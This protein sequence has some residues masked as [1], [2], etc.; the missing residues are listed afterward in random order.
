MKIIFT[1]L[2][3]FIVVG[4]S[5]AAIHWSIAV[6]CIAL[7]DAWPFLANFLGWLIAMFISFLGHY[8]LTFQ[9]QMKSLKLAAKRFLIISAS[10]FAINEFVFVSLLEITNI[11]YYWLLAITLVTIALLTFFFSRYWTFLHKP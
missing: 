8:F 5:A 3:W 9:H 4:C 7:F 2:G 6:L 1:Q 10:G 11:P